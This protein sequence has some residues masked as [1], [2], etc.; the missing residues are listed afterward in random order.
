MVDGF[1]KTV[2]TIISELDYEYLTNAKGLHEK[3]RSRETGEM[4]AQTSTCKR[5]PPIT[6]SGFPPSPL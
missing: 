4:R 1:Y 6:P 3:W 5:R 2:R